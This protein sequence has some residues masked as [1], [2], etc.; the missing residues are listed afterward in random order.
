MSSPPPPDRGT[1]APIYASVGNGQSFVVDALCYGETTLTVVDSKG[2][3][4]NTTVVVEPPVWCTLS[5]ENSSSSGPR[6]YWTLPDGMLPWLLAVCVLVAVFILG[7]VVACAV[8][9][10][11]SEHNP[12]EPK[13]KTLEE[14]RAKQALI[15]E[16]VRVETEADEVVVP[17][18]ES[19]HRSQSRSKKT[20]ATKSSSNSGGGDEGAHAK[21]RH[22]KKKKHSAGHGD[23]LGDVDMDEVA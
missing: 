23:D 1:H 16:D 12:A 14:S 3:A 2:C 15:S 21:K 17:E 4:A 22:P 10:C 8:W 9:S 6:D 13:L 20:K 7:T 19:H 18:P 11:V 5:T